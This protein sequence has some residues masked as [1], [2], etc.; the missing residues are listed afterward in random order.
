MFRRKMDAMENPMLDFS[1]LPRFDLVQAEH[2][3]PAIKQLLDRCNAVVSELEKPMAEVTWDNFVTPLDDCTEQL[4]RAWSIAGHL[5]AVVD[6][7]ELRAA[8]NENIPAVTAFWTVLSQNLALYEKYKVIRNASSFDGLSAARKQLVENTLRDF[9][10]GGAELPDEQKKVYAGIQEKAASLSTR[11]AENVLDATNHYELLVTDEKD[12]AGLP[13]DVCHMARSLAEAE[14]KTGWK[15]TLH[16]PSFFPVMQYA[17]NRTLREKMYRAN[18]TR[19]SEL[20][21]NLEWDNTGIIQELL[22]LRKQ[23]AGLLGYAN[24]A[25]VSLVPKMADTPEE[26]L[27]FLEELA[28]RAKPFAEKDWAQLKDFAASEL[29][30]SD[31]AAWDVA[32]VSEKLRQKQYAFSEEEVKQYF[33][34]NKVV[35]GLFALVSKLYGITV[36]PDTAPVWHKDV[37]FFRIE[38]DGQLVGQLYMDLYA[39]NGKRGGAWMDDARGRRLTAKGLQTPVAYLNCNFTHPVEKD[40]VLIPSLFRHDEVQTLFHEFGHCLHHLLTQVDDL[41]VSGISGVEWDAVE[42]PSQFMENFCWEWDVIQGMSSHIQTGEQLPRAL[43]DRMLKA[44]N[45]QSGMAML[46]QVEFALV[47]MHLHYDYDPDSTKTPRDILDGI[48]QRIAVNVPPAFNRFLNAFSHIFAGGYCA[49]YYSYKWAEV[50][51]AD[52][53]SAFEEAAEKEGSI[54]SPVMGGKFLAEVLSK[55]G[56]RPA[57][58]SFEAF[59]GRRPTID[60]LLRHS[61]LLS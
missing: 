54:V 38:K 44:K 27:R 33:P 57:I 25:E 34:E 52:V 46:R 7:P 39:R 26:V 51:S 10:L 32:Y 53:F 24:F 30:I 1:G 21:E 28:S 59:R 15:F 12:L 14:Q 35:G 47:D 6:T 23:E 61:G 13:E 4:S 37:K 40:G 41:G 11:F 48:R 56:S 2:I 31:L 29:N 18:C 20:G 5:C 9:R 60:A 49:G 43:F 16:F 45:F 17:D 22:R 50:L 19:A 58:E 3:T 55:G 42:L 36:K 8:Y